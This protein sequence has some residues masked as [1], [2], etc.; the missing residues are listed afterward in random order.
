VTGGAVG[1]AIAA[2]RGWAARQQARARADQ[3]R[4]GRRQHATELFSQAIG[5]LGDPKL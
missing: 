4:I 3:A 2:W 5:Q 1:L